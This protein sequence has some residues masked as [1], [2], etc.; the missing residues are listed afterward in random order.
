[1]YVTSSSK[2]GGGNM[3]WYNI[4]NYYYYFSATRS[5]FINCNN[6]STRRTEQRRNKPHRLGK[7]R[8]QELMEGVTLENNQRQ[9]DTTYFGLHAKNKYIT[10]I[11]NLLLVTAAAAIIYTAVAVLVFILY[12]QVLFLYISNLLLCT[13]IIII[14]TVCIYI[15]FTI[16]SNNILGSA[17]S[18]SCSSCGRA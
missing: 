9:T 1:M 15:I 13:I 6:I 7:R 5:Q 12:S 8:T 18:C 11:T 2:Y 3:S 10:I 17:A 16:G 4:Y 14:T